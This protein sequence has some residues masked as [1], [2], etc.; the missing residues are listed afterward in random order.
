[1]FTNEQLKVFIQR[2]QY[3]GNFFDTFNC[4]TEEVQEKP[5]RLTYKSP[6]AG[7]VIHPRIL[8]VLEDKLARPLM[9][10]FN[11]SIET[12]LHLNTGNQPT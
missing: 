7:S 4:S 10:I 2:D 6:H 1:M 8:R 9:H 3:E 5:Q 11:N 12:E